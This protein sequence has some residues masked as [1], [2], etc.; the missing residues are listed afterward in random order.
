[1]KECMNK[2][3]LMNELL[4]GGTITQIAK[5]LGSLQDDLSYERWQD[6]LL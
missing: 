6:P 1:M 3:R 4:K 5:N 2:Y